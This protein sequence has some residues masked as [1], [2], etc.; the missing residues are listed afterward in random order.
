MV[1]NKQLNN[2]IKEVLKSFIIGSSFSCN[3]AKVPPVKILVSVLLLL[4]IF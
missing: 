1:V 2:L 4:A 3:I